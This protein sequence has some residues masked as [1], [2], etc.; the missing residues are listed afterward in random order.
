MTT[1]APLPSLK[2]LEESLR[3]YECGL[4][5]K[6]KDFLPERHGQRH[7]WTE[8]REHAVANCA[9]R[10]LQLLSILPLL[11]Y[12]QHRDGCASFGAEI[13]KG[14]GW[15]SVVTKYQDCDCGLDTLK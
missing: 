8:Y 4:E 13:I 7:P 2:E 3:I 6:G 11:E 10:T 5:L 1:P 14:E 12:V 15:N 9:L